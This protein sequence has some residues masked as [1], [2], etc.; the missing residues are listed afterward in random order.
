MFRLHSRTIV[1]FLLIFLIL[2]NGQFCSSNKKKCTSIYNDNI[3]LHR[4]ANAE[5]PTQW[6]WHLPDRLQKDSASVFQS[7]P[8]GPEDSPWF[9]LPA[10]RSKHADCVLLPKGRIGK[11]WSKLLKIGAGKKF[12]ATKTETYWAKRQQPGAAWPVLLSC[13]WDA[14]TPAVRFL[15]LLHFEAMQRNQTSVL[16]CRPIIGNLQ[17]NGHCG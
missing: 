8:R 13:L 9:L 7:A 11:H 12:S 15:V 4:R 16:V 10:N 14:M 5:T 3:D 1:V 2:F 6:A 17:R